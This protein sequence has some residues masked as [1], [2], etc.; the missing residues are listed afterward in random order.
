[1]R[2]IIAD[3]HAVFRQD[4]RL[5]L[6]LQ[7]DIEIVAEVDRAERLLPVLTA[8]PCDVLL[9]DL[10]MDRWVVE[11]IEQLARLTWVC[12]LT[13]SERIED[14]NG[15]PA[16]GRPGNRSETLRRRKADR[17]D[18]DRGRWTG[19]G[20]ANAAGGTGRPNGSAW[21]K[22]TDGQGVGYRPLCRGRAA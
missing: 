2:L 17:G 9:L 10:Q 6:A 21:R 8:T 20:P 12:V 16:N 15:R 13:A 4:L 11:E 7:D 14:A 3:D 18:S 1:M 19:V 5:L 22:E